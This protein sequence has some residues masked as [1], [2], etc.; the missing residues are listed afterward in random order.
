VAAG[1]TVL[2]YN[3]WRQLLRADLRF[4]D[5]VAGPRDLAPLRREASLC[6]SVR[7]ALGLSVRI[8][9]GLSVRIALGLSVRIALGLSVRMALIGGFIMHEGRAELVN[10]NM[11]NV[12]FVGFTGKKYM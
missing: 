3:P 4:P 10:L 7:I 12:S 8:A 11:R 6:L 5:S 2:E 9:L 1:S